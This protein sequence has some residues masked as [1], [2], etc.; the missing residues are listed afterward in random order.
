MKG[1]DIDVVEMLESLGVEGVKEHFDEVEFECPFGSHQA[2]GSASMNKDTTAWFCFGCKSSGNA[3]SFVSMFEGVPPWTA[4]R[5]LKQRYGGGFREPQGGMLAEIGN[6][7]SRAPEEPRRQPEP[8]EWPPEI[9]LF[10]WNDENTPAHRWMVQERGFDPDVLNAWQLSHDTCTNRI[11]I[12]VHRKDGALIGFK[13]R[14]IP[15]DANAQM[16]YPKYR[17]LGYTD[18]ITTGYTFPTYDIGSVLFG[19]WRCN[20]TDIVLCEG[21]LNVVALHAAGI[22]AVATAHSTVTN[23]QLSLLRDHASRVTVWFDDDE[24]G[25]NGT[26]G[27]TNSRGHRIP[28]IVEVLSPFMSVRVVQPQR[29]DPADLSPQERVDAVKNAVS[30]FVKLVV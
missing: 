16:G 23:T 8:I 18:R 29:G 20:G 25:R 21:E 1:L 2:G 27:W 4:Q 12:P 19:Q 11:A 13:G 10:D 7:L 24:A 9:Q 5:W 26:Y 6:L 3:V 22:E 14:L 17:V 28:G 15:F 30:P